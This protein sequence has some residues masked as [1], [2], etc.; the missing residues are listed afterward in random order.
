MR[1]SLDFLAGREMR[2]R[3]P[4]VGQAIVEG[5]QEAQS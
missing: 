2:S 3:S 5:M 1:V 4:H